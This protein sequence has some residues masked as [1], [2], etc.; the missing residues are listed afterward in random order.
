MSDVKA[1]D[2]SGHNVKITEDVIEEFKS[3]LHGRLITEQDEYYDS[4][5]KIWNGIIDKKPAIIVYC[6]GVAD[7]IRTVNFS[8]IHHLRT[9]VR[10]GGHNVAGGA[11]NDGG[12]VIDLSK[13]RSVYVDPLN[14]RVRVQGGV[15]LGDIDHE[16]QVFGLATPTGLVTETG[17]AGLTLRGGFGH[18]TRKY[19]LT[20]D[21]L[22]SVDIVTA[23][24]K[25]IKASSDE[26]SDLFWAIRG[27][28][29]NFGIVVSFE[30]RLHPVGPEVLFIMNLYPADKGK[31]ALLFLREYM[32]RA[33][34]EL[35]LITFYGTM[36]DNEDV[37][38]N[39][40]GRDV[41][42]FYGC[43]TGPED[44]R[45]EILSDI[46]QF[47]DPL[48]DVSG[49]TQFI[50]AQSALDEDYPDGLRYYW[51]SLYFTELTDEIIESLHNWGTN[52][53]S[54][55]STLDFWFIGGALNNVD[56][57]ETA[58][59]KR[60]AQYMLGIEANWISPTEDEINIQWARNTWDD[61]HKLSKG[62][63]Y[64][65]FAGFE[66]E[67]ETLLKESYGDNYN[68][69]MEIKEKYDPQHIF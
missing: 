51:K 38:L 9:S 27:G 69:L 57:S 6:S 47:G 37:P 4:A 59:D 21:N 54:E 28:G 23:D 17:I 43:Y 19:G 26:N 13:M 58:F 65:N 16:T 14:H 40:R 18:L 63:L 24:G 66:E 22:I 56:P 3:I 55:L 42:V 5:R 60:D 62:G 36:P 32:K 67:R 39:V 33:P 7:V 2:I 1:I 64:L 31:D 48:V 61:L 45:V 8:R 10:S 25:L 20:S 30:Y 44:K 12:I 11:I 35:G 49:P 50:K 29:L 68:R 15:R 46:R 53:A 52:R 41:F 34:K